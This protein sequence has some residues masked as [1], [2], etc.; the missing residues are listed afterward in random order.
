MWATEAQDRRTELQVIS[1]ALRHQHIAYLKTFFVEWLCEQL[2]SGFSTSSVDC[3]FLT[4]PSVR[5]RKP[6]TSSVHVGD[7]LFGPGLPG[8]SCELVVRVVSMRGKKLRLLV[9]RDGLSFCSQVGSKVD[10][11]AD[12][13]LGLF[14]KPMRGELK[15]LLDEQ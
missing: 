13:I 12:R 11:H 7:V 3:S 1:A 4:H 14:G 5:R 2:D 15:R 6:A 8:S 10:W 9:L